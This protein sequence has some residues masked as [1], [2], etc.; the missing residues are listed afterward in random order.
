[1]KNK[2]LLKSFGS[3][4]KF[5]N[6]NFVKLNALSF[7]FK[8]S[9]FI[10]GKR[11]DTYFYKTDKLVLFLNE[12]LYFYV[13]F[14]KDQNKS[15]FFS[16]DKV[17]FLFGKEACLRSFQSIFFGKYNG[18]FFT[19]NSKKDKQYQNLFN[20]L[21]MFLFLSIKDYVFSF[22]ELNLL[23]KPFIV[24]S[25]NNAKLENYLFYKILFKD[26]A[27]FFQYCLLRLLSDFL[28]KIQLC[29]YIESKSVH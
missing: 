14:F 10:L 17:G 16:D 27:H 29:N 19:N 6:K 28:I 3:K 24:F 9:S 5:I 13:N 23:N 22:K 12:I 7:N 15:L 21:D 8:N 18:G 2:L 20:R 1:M 26:D 25:K 4:T 11:N